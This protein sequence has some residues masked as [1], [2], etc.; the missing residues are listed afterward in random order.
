[1]G[2]ATYI[3]FSANLDRYYVGHAQDPD[4][5][6]LRDH[7]A[8]RNRSTK[9]G[10]PW[11]HR[12]VQWHQTRAQAMDVER[13]IKARKSRAFIEALIASAG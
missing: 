10:I 1:M 11:E 7:N 13:M 3:L 9:A 2:Y 5:R 12:W 6:L 4:V 8:G